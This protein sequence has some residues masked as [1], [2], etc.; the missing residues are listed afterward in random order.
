MAGLPLEDRDDWAYTLPYISRTQLWNNVVRGAPRPLCHRGCGNMSGDGRNHK[1]T[2]E[3]SQIFVR[4]R[5]I[6]KMVELHKVSA[7]LISETC[8]SINN[9][10]IS[11]SIICRTWM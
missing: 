6:L 2:S 9:L 7:T 4:G 5:G 3:I 11:K 8:T 1:E 10:N